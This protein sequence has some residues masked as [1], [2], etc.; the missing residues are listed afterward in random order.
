MGALSAA[1]VLATDG[2]KSQP[3]LFV[4]SDVMAG[5]SQLGVCGQTLQLFCGLLNEQSVT[6]S[7]PLT[8]LKN[9]L[10]QSKFDSW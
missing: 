5:L 1:A 7:S 6:L 9:I 3:A 2:V 8:S 4:K 10:V